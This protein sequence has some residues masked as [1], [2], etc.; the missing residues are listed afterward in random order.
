M[1]PVSQ[2]KV[3]LNNGVEMPLVGFGTFRIRSAEVIMSVVESALASGYRLFDTATVYG[4][5]K[6]LGE[7]LRLLLPKFG[8][9]RQDIFI[10]TK[11]SPRDAHTKEIIKE[12]CRK[13]LA[14][15]GFEKIDL[16]LIHFPGMANLSS[17]D[18]QNIKLRSQAWEALVECYNEGLVRSIGVSN[19]TIRHLQELE[20]RNYGVVP[21]VNQVECHPY[22]PQKE[23]LIYCQGT[24]IALQAYCSLGGT[25]SGIASLIHDPVVINAAQKL[26]VSSGQL[27]LA[28]ATQQGISVIPKSTHADRIK[29]NISLNFKIPD[30]YMKA[31]DKLGAKN[32]KYAWDPSTVA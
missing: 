1:E 16:Y 4:N 30:E 20:V 25:S 31:L 3:L 12:A 19:Y 27:L 23:L 22:F 7:A 29:E 18:I 32:T 21:A 6:Y 9:T 13:S 8:L 11:L 5:E 15:L 26:G 17:A 28:W 10:T 14:S 2:K 24:G